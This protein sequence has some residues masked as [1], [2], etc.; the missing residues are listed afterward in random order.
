MKKSQRS[1]HKNL[2]RDPEGNVPL[3]TF[4][5]NGGYNVKV[6]V[7]APAAFYAETV[8]RYVIYLKRDAHFKPSSCGSRV[9]GGGTLHM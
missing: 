7:V 6:L 1:K 8:D 4:K 3:K 5:I 2:A 9:N